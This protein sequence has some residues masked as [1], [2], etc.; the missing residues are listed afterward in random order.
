MKRSKKNNRWKKQLISLTMLA[1]LIPFSAKVLSETVPIVGDAAGKAAVISAGLA[2]PEGGRTLLQ[3]EIDQSPDEDTITPEDP[4]SSE[5][6]AAPASETNLITDADIPPTSG[7]T[8]EEIDQ[9]PNNDGAVVR[10][11]YTAGSTDDYINISGNAYVRNMT[12]LPNQ[13]VID[14]VH[15]PP[16]FTITPGTS[17]PQ[18]LIMHTHTTESYALSDND[19]YDINYP[20]RNLDA[21]RNV[22]RV[23]DEITKQLEAAG[24]GVIHD[25]TVH[26]YPSYNGS[27]DRSKQTVETILAQYPSIKVVLDIH[28]D[29]I[30]TDDGTRYAPIANIDGRNAAQI[31]IISGCDDGTMD[32]P[33]YLQNLAFASVLEQQVESDYPGLTR[34]ISFKYKYYNQSLTTGS[35]LIEV[36][37][38]SNSLD[39]AIYSGYLLGKS[40][41][42]TLQGLTG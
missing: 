7:I 34:P 15:S 25:T 13:T 10:K 14:A 40:L 12:N 8:Q 31:M 19:Y 18:V 38:N 39:E 3:E 5:G 1:I 36:G 4:I 9:Y 37:S 23:G 27:Y 35:L 21:T 20:S 42:K 6:E 22:V 32:Y 28:R 11:T 26:D 16:A 24:I 41:A 29:A 2:L 30:E 33:N 17:E